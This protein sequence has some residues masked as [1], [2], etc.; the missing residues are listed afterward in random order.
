[1]QNCGWNYADAQSVAAG[2]MNSTGHRENMLSPSVSS[3]G[4]AYGPGPYWTMIAR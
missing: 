1:V 4:I 2:W 3:F